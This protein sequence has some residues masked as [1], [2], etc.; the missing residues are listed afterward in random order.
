MKLIE[1]KKN[2]LDQ[3]IIK[4]EDGLFERIFNVEANKASLIN[5]NNKYF[6]SEV[7]SINQ[8]TRDLEDEEIRDAI[9]SQLKIKYIAEN[10]IKIV[11]QL[12]EG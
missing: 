2:K 3:D 9:T 12:S 7:E 4:L 8:I 1:I 6:L 10:N 11:K 5:L